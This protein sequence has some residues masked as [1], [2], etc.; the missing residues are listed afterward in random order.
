M[1]DHDSVILIFF[2]LDDEELPVY[3]NHNSIDV[4]TGG[5]RSSISQSKFKCC[6]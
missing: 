4:F 5:E 6:Q 1:F 2:R 3:R